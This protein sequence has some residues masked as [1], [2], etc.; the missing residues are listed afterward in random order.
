MS[1]NNSEGAQFF[2]PPTDNPT[3][4]EHEDGSLTFCLSK[5]DEEPQFDIE[6]V[7]NG[8]TIHDFVNGIVPASYIDDFAFHGCTSLESLTLSNSLVSIGQ[9]AFNGMFEL[10]SVELPAG[11]TVIGDRAF[12]GAKKITSLSIPNSVN[13]MGDQA[14]SNCFLLESITVSA[15]VPPVCTNPFYNTSGGVVPDLFSIYVP[16]ESVTAYKAAA[17]WSNHSSRIFAII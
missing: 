17:G 13:S 16:S 14:F 9:Y 5:K 12:T 2:T 4:V 8:E 1:P 11:L 3:F 6:Y 10:T 7:L 15:V